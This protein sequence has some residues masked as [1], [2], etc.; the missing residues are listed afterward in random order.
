[1]KSKNSNDVAKCL[2]AYFA[3]QGVPKYMYTDSDQSFRGATEALLRTYG[4]NHVTSYPYTQKENSVEA[5]V[6]IFKNAYRAAILEN[7]I[8]KIA[9]W[10][11]LYPI[12]I[13]RINSLI[14]KYGM[15]RE[16]VH[17]GTIVESSLPLI[18]DCE[19]FNPLDEDLKELS[20]RFRDKIGRYLMKKKR[21][22]TLYKIGKERKF[23]M[24]ELVMKANYTAD[25]L[26]AVVYKGPYRIVHLD[27]GGARIKDIKT[28]DE[29]SVS[30]EHI[31]K[32]KIDELLTL[33]PQNFDSEITATLDKY[34]YKSSGTPRQENTEET[35]AEE[36]EPSRRLR[37]GKLYHVTADRIG[38]RVRKDAENAY[39]RK[40]KVYSI[41]RNN[42]R[43]SIMIMHNSYSREILYEREYEKIRQPFEKQ[44]T[45]D[46]KRQSDKMEKRKY[47]K[48][49]T[50]SFSS[51]DKGTMVIRMSRNDEERPGTRVK[52]KEIIIHFC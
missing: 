25:S 9:Q 7:N 5:Q 14:S 44:D 19:L 48:N 47:N 32:I 4:V 39:W 49:R 13:C 40:D 10:D 33:L 17:F 36:Q 50:S 15:S 41:G 12:V 27:E 43:E 26:L 24:Y 23:F 35:K 29:Q 18:T 11:C 31:R 38:E 34:R 51:A 21:D 2:R 20:D 3:A 22:K 42:K 52:F 1:M 30:F 46:I 37:S 8:F 28:G 45:T 6:R 16:S